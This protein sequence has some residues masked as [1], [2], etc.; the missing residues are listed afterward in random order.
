[1]PDDTLTCQ[2]VLLDLDR[3]IEGTLPP[4]RLDLVV[5]HVRDCPRCAAFGE[6]YARTVTALRALPTPDLPATATTRLL[7]RLSEEP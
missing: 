7:E 6:A 3:Y 2:E 5:A 4:A 1:M